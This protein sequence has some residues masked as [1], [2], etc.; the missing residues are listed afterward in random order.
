VRRCVVFVLLLTGC[1]GANSSKSTRNGRQMSQATFRGLP[2]YEPEGPPKIVPP[3]PKPPL[4]P[5]TEKRRAEAAKREEEE[6][7]RRTRERE[8][9]KLPSTEQRRVILTGDALTN[10]GLAGLSAD[11]LTIVS[12]YPRQFPKVS[13]ADL[14]EALAVYGDKKGARDH[15]A[16]LGITDPD[17]ELRLR[18][19]FGLASEPTCQSALAVSKELQRVGLAGLDDA[20]RSFVA[21]N[22]QLFPIVA[23]SA[24]TRMP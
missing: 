10:K 22:P 3:P 14:A 8:F 16:N 12:R 20:A 13:A 24:S 17:K 1:S 9:T 5:E 19:A 23:P 7:R 11:E 15:A 4:D 21:H 18:A 6:R 2:A